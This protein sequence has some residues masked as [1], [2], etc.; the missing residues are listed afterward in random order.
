MEGET[1][2]SIAADQKARELYESG[3]PRA[4]HR[5]LERWRVGAE[6]CGV[7]KPDEP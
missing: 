7:G 3:E 6:T 2:K 4:L 5:Y 1:M